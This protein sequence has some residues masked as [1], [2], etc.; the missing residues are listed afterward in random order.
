M[1]AS[2]M[3]I[4]FKRALALA[5]LALVV[6]AAIAAP[7]AQASGF[8]GPGLEAI[9]GRIV[10]VG[11]IGVVMI[12][13]IETPVLLTLHWSFRNRVLVPRLGWAL[14]GGILAMVP[15]VAF[16]MPGEALSA[17]ISET[18]DASPMIFA[19]EWLPFIVGNG[20]FGWHLFSPRS[21]PTAG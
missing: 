18:L 11:L 8:E 9:V 16:N 2:S 10:G 1:A 3:T 5:V 20:V 12:V 7:L 4:N 6:S 13:V 17:K 19:S 14:I 21:I 15:V